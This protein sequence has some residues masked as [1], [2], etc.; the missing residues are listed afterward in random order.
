MHTPN[1]RPISRHELVLLI[2]LCD[3]V[4]L[5]PGRDGEWLDFTGPSA[6][7]WILCMALPSNAC[8]VLRPSQLSPVASD[9]TRNPRLPADESGVFELR[10]DTR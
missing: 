3:T 10:A 6:G 1:H 9:A 2:S 4:V 8:L 7:T 5:L